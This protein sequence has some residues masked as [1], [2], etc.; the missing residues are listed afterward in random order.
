MVLRAM[1]M[2]E[3][4]SGAIAY[5]V[6]GEGEN[7]VVMLPSGAHERADF[8]PLREL[9]GDQ[10]RTIALDWP[11]HGDSP[12]AAGGYSAIRFADLAE[13]VVEQLAPEGAVVL[14]NSVGGFAAGR[15]AIRRPE[16]VRG[17]VLVDS[18]GFSGRGAQVRAFCALMGRPAFLRRIY[19]TFSKRYMQVQGKA[20]LEAR[21]R[22]IAT[23][24][25]EQGLEVVSGLWKSF[26]SAEHDLRTEASSITA[27]TL[28]VWGSRDRVMSPRIGRAAAAMISNSRLAV[29]DTGHCPHIS[30]PKGF[31]KELVPFL[32]SVFEGEPVETSVHRS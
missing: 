25:S 5:D 27:P 30:D 14:G 28:V 9:L 16:L 11:G 18:G 15:L 12:V 21:E 3:T 2:I 4:P 31:A 7:V 29:L 17:L 24:R 13:E 26:A 23:I 10:L 8:D 19:P 22:A 1:E 32:D 20:D 6:R